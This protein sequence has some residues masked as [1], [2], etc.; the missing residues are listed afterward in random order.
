MT[1]LGAWSSPALS[2]SPSG[3]SALEPDGAGGEYALGEGAGAKLWRLGEAGAALTL[4]PR[5]AKVVYGEKVGVAGYLTSA[6]VPLEG[7]LV[8]ISSTSAAG[9]TSAA[10]TATTD[11][12][13]FY[14]A[15]I[16]P[17]AT[18]AWTA[19]ATGPAGATIVS[20]TFPSLEVA[21]EVSIALTNRKVGSG[22]VETFSGAV[23]P[24]HAGSR[25][26]VQQQS[27]G[28]WRTVAGG[29]L[30]AGSRYRVSWPLPRRA[31]T[32]L[33]RTL[34]PAHTDHAAGVSRTVRL[35]VVVGG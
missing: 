2:P 28:S 18:A 9:V 14:E 29:S 17:K 26:L 21:P 6:G 11:G 23:E 31:A 24:A 13:G 27:G 12:E 15:T 8:K 30:D 25:V 7:S 32:Y 10:A 4:R 33:L 20:E 3:L 1:Y 5:A 22:Y 19:A 16:A 35:R 34:V